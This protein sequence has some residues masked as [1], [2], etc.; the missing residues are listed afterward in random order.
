M[1]DAQTCSG[2]D[3][4]IE[5]VHLSKVY[6]DGQV[7]ALQ[8]VNLAIRHGEYVAIMGP[9]GSGKSTLLNLLGALDLP[10]EGHVCFDGKPLDARR[11]LDAVRAKKIGF[12]FQSF[13]LLPTLSAVEN[14]QI[15]MFELG[16]S[17]S[18]RTEKANRLLEDVGMGHRLRHLPNRL[19]VGERQRVAIARSLAN[20]P[21]LLLADEPTG[22][23]D[24]KTAEDILALFAKLH[25]ERSMTLLVITHSEEVGQRADRVIRI[26]DGQ[27]ESDGLAGS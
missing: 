1:N 12:V 11:N 7:N 18:E 21:M 27:I 10:T 25:R 26:R 13:H 3:L 20:D 14:V 9:S 19:S 15:P 16:M 22:N 23:L 2:S 5:A 6:T 17:P 8:D 24:T 4:L